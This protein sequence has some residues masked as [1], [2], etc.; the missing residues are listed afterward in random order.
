EVEHERL[1]PAKHGKVD[2][3]TTVDAREVERRRGRMVT[4]VERL[5]DGRRVL[6]RPAPDQ[7]RE[8]A[9]DDGD[10]ECLRSQPDGACHQ[11]ATM[12][13][14]VPISTWLK[15]HSACRMCMRMQPCETE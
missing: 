8:Q 15:S 9:H 10:C 4:V 11:A 6:G 5:R 7:Q 12:K 2:A 1:L 3:T 14:V 13:T